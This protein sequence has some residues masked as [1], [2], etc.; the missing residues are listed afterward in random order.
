M[1]AKKGTNLCVAVNE[2]QIELPSPFARLLQHLLARAE[3][4]RGVTL[5]NL[6][7]ILAAVL[8][9]RMRFYSV[10]NTELHGITKSLWQRAHKRL[11]Q[12]ARATNNAYVCS[13][14]S[15]VSSV[16]Q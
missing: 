10:R 5:L 1:V 13:D 11:E 8:Y 4:K 12:V 9:P 15:F 7:D 3:T 2:T 14:D 6:N 16:S